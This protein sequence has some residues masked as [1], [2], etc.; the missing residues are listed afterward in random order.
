[1]IKRIHFGLLCLIAWCR[2]CGRNVPLIPPKGPAVSCGLNGKGERW[3]MYL[4]HAFE[5]Y[6]FT[7]NGS[8]TYSTPVSDPYLCPYC[9][10]LVD[11]EAKRCPSCPPEQLEFKI[12]V[13]QGLVQEVIPANF[14]PDPA[15]SKGIKISVVDL[16]ND[17]DEVNPEEHAF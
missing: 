3:S 2:G 14:T 15:K 7:R 17:P 16:D 9:G 13:N 6:C 4:N 11:S 10:Y 1:M 8:A 5:P 12:I